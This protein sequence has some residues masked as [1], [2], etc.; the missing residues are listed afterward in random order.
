MYNASNVYDLKPKFVAEK[1]NLLLGRPS[2]QSMA[3]SHNFFLVNK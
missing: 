1:T 3:G 2:D